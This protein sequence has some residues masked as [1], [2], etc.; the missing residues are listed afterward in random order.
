MNF[1]AIDFE[2]ANEKRN[3]A[4]S[5]GIT[6]VENNRIVDE[7]YFLIKPPEMRFVPQN[8]WIHNILPEDVIN[9]R[10]FDEIWPEIKEY[11]EGELVVSHNA[12]FDFSVLRSLL[13]TYNIE[14]PFLKYA[15]TV[16]LSQ[17][18]IEDVKNHKLNTMAEYVGHEFN[19]HHA[20]ED[21]VAC[22][23]IMIYICEKLGINDY[24]S[25]NLKG[26]L[27]LGE[28][29]EKGYTPCSSLIKRK[30]VITKK[31]ALKEVSLDLESNYFRDKVLV[32]T[33]PLESMKRYEASE[34]VY[35]LGGS[36]GSSVTKKTQ[37]LV[38]GIKNRERMDLKYKST[39][40]RKAER[41]ISE[42][43]EIEIISE[44]EFLRLT[45]LR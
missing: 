9:E 43:Q 27:T 37:V 41:L 24:V 8:I 23:K 25:L 19:H 44:E 30:N 29:Y 20:G 13:D 11:F 39:K 28:I 33:G 1:T 14:Y 21:A 7:K 16:I 36:V 4:C 18:H 45:G 32:F 15:C 3:S 31:E 10:T 34:I 6:R 17:N 22:A 42:G 26:G 40:L 38:T 12:S 2:T 35:R 5:I